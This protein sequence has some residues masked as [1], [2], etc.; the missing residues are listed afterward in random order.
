MPKKASNIYLCIFECAKESILKFSGDND[1]EE[2]IAIGYVETKNDKGN[3]QIRVPKD[4]NIGGNDLLNLGYKLLMV[5]PVV[6][7]GSLS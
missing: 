3:F 6:D 4:W 2:T 1:I 5:K 7:K